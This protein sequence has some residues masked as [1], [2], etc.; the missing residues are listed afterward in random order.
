MAESIEDILGEE[1]VRALTEQPKQLTPEERMAR[2]KT[3]AEKEMRLFD[4]FPKK[5]RDF[6]N[7][8]EVAI[9]P[10]QADKI[11]WDCGNN[12]DEAIK[13][14]KRKAHE[15]QAIVNQRRSLH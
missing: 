7:N 12:I 11:L 15:L 2:R 3:V 4:R 5:L 8:L 6:L 1:I 13:T 9:E 14:M 10:T